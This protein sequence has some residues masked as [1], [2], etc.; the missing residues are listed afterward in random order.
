MSSAL[1]T[2][3]DVRED[4]KSSSRIDLLKINEKVKRTIEKYGGKA[5]IY[6]DKVY[7][8]KGPEL[9]KITRDNLFEDEPVRLGTYCIG[10]ADVLVICTVTSSAYSLKDAIVYKNAL[11]K[12]IQIVSEAY[13]GIENYEKLVKF[14]TEKEERKRQEHIR[15]MQ[16]LAEEFNSLPKVLKTWKIG[17]FKVVLERGCDAKFRTSWSYNKMFQ[18]SVNVLLFYKGK[19]SLP[20]KYLDLHKYISEDGRILRKKFVRDFDHKFP[21]EELIELALFL[22]EIWNAKKEV[23]DKYHLW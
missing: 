4:E 8:E 9:P 18:G 14:L 16:Q 12:A 3:N 5:S 17:K 19:I 15:K 20:V 6:K 21:E 22:K 23:E 2:R 1:E 10:G 13:D 7:L 11:E